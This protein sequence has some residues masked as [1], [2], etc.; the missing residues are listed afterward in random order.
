MAKTP[1]KKRKRKPPAPP[2]PAARKEPM[3]KKLAEMG[4]EDKKPDSAAA[5]LARLRRIEGAS[6][7]GKL[8]GKRRWVGMT[9]EQRKE[10]MRKAAKARWAKGPKKEES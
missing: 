9:P 1:K 10:M 4:I 3:V 2:P 8:G 7:M 5:E 6:S